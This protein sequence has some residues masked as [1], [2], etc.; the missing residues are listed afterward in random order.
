MPR[1]NLT[2][3]TL[4]ALQKVSLTPEQIATIDK[5]RE[6]G[7]DVEII[8]TEKQNLG[9]VTDDKK[10]PPKPKAK[11][12]AKPKSD[13]KEPK[14]PAKKRGRPPSA[15]IQE[16]RDLL[17]KTRQ[18][19]DMLEGIKQ[20][21]IPPLPTQA[22][23]T[24]LFT[25]PPVLPTNPL[26]F[27]PEQEP[28]H[29]APE[30][31]PFVPETRAPSIPLIEPSASDK[32]D[33]IQLPTLSQPVGL[34][35]RSANSDPA[36][37]AERKLNDEEYRG[38]ADINLDEKDEEFYVAN[39]DQL[40][41]VN[42]HNNKIN[43]PEEMDEIMRD[44]F[45]PNDEPPRYDETIAQ[46][47]AEYLQ[48][49]IRLGRFH[50]PGGIPIQDPELKQNSDQYDRLSQPLYIQALNSGVQGSNMTV[51]PNA[52]SEESQIM[53][54]HHMKHLYI[55]KREPI[56]MTVAAGHSGYV[57]TADIS[58]QTADFV[59]DEHLIQRK[60]IR[61]FNDQGTDPIASVVNN[62][63]LERIKRQNAILNEANRD[64]QAK[65][66][67]YLMLHN[68]LEQENKELTE[69]FQL[70]QDE[71]TNLR[72]DAIIRNESH[73]NVLDDW[74][75]QV[76]ALQRA[77][78]DYEEQLRAANTEKTQ[79]LV[80][81]EREVNSLQQGLQQQIDGNAEKDKLLAKIRDA[82]GQQK[83]VMASQ[84]KMLQDTRGRL[85]G[86]NQSIEQLEAEVKNKTERME[87]ALQ[88]H[89]YTQQ[90]K[91][92]IQEHFDQYKQ[93]AA[94]ERQALAEDY[95]ALETEFASLRKSGQ[96]QYEEYKNNMVTMQTQRQADQLRY[97][98]SMNEYARSHESRFLELQKSKDNL[99][100]EAL[101]RLSEKDREIMQQRIN[102]QQSQAQTKAE[103]DA[104]R[105]TLSKAYELS[106]KY[107][108][109]N[110]LLNQYEQ[111][112]AHMNRELQRIAAHQALLPES[113][114]AQFEQD[115]N[116]LLLESNRYRDGYN[117]VRQVRDQLLLEHPNIAS[118]G[119]EPEQ[120]NSVRVEEVHDQ[121]LVPPSKEETD[122]K[123]LANAENNNWMVQRSVNSSLS[124][125]PSYM[126]NTLSTEQ[127]NAGRN[128]K[129]EISPEAEALQYEIGVNQEAMDLAN[130]EIAEVKYGRADEIALLGG[131]PSSKV[132]EKDGVFMDNYHP[133]LERSD[134]FQAHQAF[135]YDD[136][137]HLEDVKMDVNDHPNGFVEDNKMEDES[138]QSNPAE[139]R[140]SARIADQFPINYRAPD[141]RSNRDY[142]KR[143]S[144]FEMRGGT[145]L[146][147]VHP[148]MP[149]HHY[150][151]SVHGVHYTPE[152]GG[153]LRAKRPIH[154]E[155]NQLRG[156]YLLALSK[157][158]A[159]ELHQARKEGRPARIHLSHREL[160]MNWKYRHAMKGTG[161]WDTI[162]SG[163]SAVGNAVS[164]AGKYAYNNIIKPAA[165]FVYDNAVDPLGNYI[166][167]HAKEYAT[168]LAKKG[169]DAVKTAASEYTGLPL[170]FIP[171]DKLVD[172]VAGNGIHTGGA[173][174]YAPSRPYRPYDR[175][176]RMR[177]GM[178]TLGGGIR[179]GGA[180]GGLSPFIH[181]ANQAAQASNG[182]VLS[183][184]YSFA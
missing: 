126:Q 120:P 60:I 79:T 155:A 156:P 76:H 173:I 80:D 132:E 161:I 21:T 56:N 129:N 149:G 152:Q 37:E 106:Q 45:S 29:P 170:N 43:D 40:R 165:G 49:Q 92:Q 7:R 33:S 78:M 177:G 112:H 94:Q 1:K 183:G 88:S 100:N 96:D 119:A 15:M 153:S 164:S 36:F 98:Q 122:I 31:A 121:L 32:I 130:D 107:A 160:L 143:G 47:P 137:P 105:Q 38:L 54:N 133:G 117:Q 55:G 67:E 61:T 103:S 93:Q 116:L 19:Q 27:P 95:H 70:L 57:D 25:P 87:E 17:A 24:A 35:T 73:E 176:G 182:I 58:T 90:E 59:P 89:Q 147:E 145:I 108:E 26:S 125:T 52:I 91:Q 162:K 2:K 181:R 51:V 128:L 157:R 64:A 104:H 118:Y 134:E 148:T 102:L 138:S 115:A 84:D 10:P 20:N 82:N 136:L 171:T 123:R 66:Q 166:K 131:V 71:N 86:V 75:N 127:T 23:S 46:S 41:S 8:I 5:A 34:L 175:D 63:G 178:H 97:Q 62:L 113:E 72:S 42:Q 68:S 184:N 163:V 169:L 81:Y 39:S 154:L 74:K 4:N 142:T 13:G 174:S 85:N 140:R 22:P 167:D 180:I 30:P 146:S 158:N 12:K 124:D 16:L 14:E 44:R 151:Y 6:A 141:R 109:T 159:A 83:T 53:G 135:R 11:R 69:R 139:S 179:V 110:H 18:H 172:S 111:A 9:A 114:Q 65:I 101:S 99:M 28:P 144:G 48:E 50:P 3:A 168:T 77:G 150:L